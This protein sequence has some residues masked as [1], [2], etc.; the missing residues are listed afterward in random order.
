M[1]PE[2]TAILRSIRRWLLAAVFLLG[3]GVVTLAHVGYVQN[4]TV[5]GFWQS[6]VFS[7]AGVLGGGGAAIA[8]LKLLGSSSVSEHDRQTTE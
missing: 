8:G 5:V 1:S 2:T 4:A 6:L 3:L 7:V